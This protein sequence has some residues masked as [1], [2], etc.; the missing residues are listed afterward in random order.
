[1]S[2]RDLINAAIAVESVGLIGENVR[3]ARKK[4]KR[5]SDILG[6]GVKNIVGT[7]LIRATAQAGEGLP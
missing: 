5:V 6:V 2:A 4:K 3:F 1:M 7:S